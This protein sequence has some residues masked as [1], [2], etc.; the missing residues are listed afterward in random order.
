MLSHI[1]KHHSFP[2]NTTNLKKFVNFFKFHADK[3]TSL[4]RWH[5]AFKIQLDLYIYTF[6][7]NCKVFQKISLGFNQLTVYP[8][9]DVIKIYLIIKQDGGRLS[10]FVSKFK[11][12]SML[13]L[14]Q[15][16]FSISDIIYIAIPFK[17]ISVSTWQIYCLNVLFAK[18]V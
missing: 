17:P 6:Y 2:T 4:S 14:L 1:I 11:K 16:F 10:T 8:A 7:V 9:C 12:Q 5:C 18:L 15:R 13:E 3:I